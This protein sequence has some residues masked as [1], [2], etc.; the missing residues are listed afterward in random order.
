MHKNQAEQTIIIKG[1]S[2][3]PPRGERTRRPRTFQSRTPCLRPLIDKR[4]EACLKM[5]VGSI[6]DAT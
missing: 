5:C 4:I 2:W 1:A 6:G 3:V